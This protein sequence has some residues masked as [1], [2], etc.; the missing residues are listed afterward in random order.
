MTLTRPSLSP[1]SGDPE[2]ARR[3][4]WL[5]A[6]HQLALADGDFSAEEERL[7]VEELQRELPG[8]TLETLHRPG[9]EALV[10]RFGAG[11][12]RAEEFLR[13]AVLVALADGHLSPIEIEWL[14]HWSEA[15]QV[16]A[17]VIGE[18][19]AGAATGGAHGICDTREQPELLEGVRR[20]LDGIDP[21]DPAVARFLVRL[22]PA[23]CPFERDVTLF[24]RKV[25][26]IPP[27]CKINP[28]YEQLVA[29][30]FRCLC[31]LEE[32]GAAATGG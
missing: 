29:L 24:G 30:R 17:P 26:H 31:R 16:G 4:L 25:V 14:R 6:L 20:W 7:L 22:I 28:L 5:A 19:V 18:L 12:P 32:I 2:A 23:Q 9:A 8:V 27:M 13:T 11:T 15:L 10:H 21:S 3:Y 1:S